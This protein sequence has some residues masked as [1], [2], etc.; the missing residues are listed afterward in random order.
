MVR[1]VAPYDEP[2][3]TKSV[4]RAVLAGYR[5]CGWTRTGAHILRHG[6]ASRLLRAGAPMKEIAD[7]R[8]T[9]SLT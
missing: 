2:I 3:T 6:M 5:R 7:I 8:T 9:N 4:K 1:H